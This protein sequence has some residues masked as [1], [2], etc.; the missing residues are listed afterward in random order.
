MWFVL[1]ALDFEFHPGT[2]ISPF[3]SE[4]TTDD[5]WGYADQM[6]SVGAFIL[7]LDG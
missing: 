3:P 5:C 6:F 4:D 7:A 1:I 2:N